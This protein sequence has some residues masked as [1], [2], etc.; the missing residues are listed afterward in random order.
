MKEEQRFSVRFPLDVLKTIKAL[1][2]EDHR[3]INSEIIWI[4]QQ[5]IATHQEKETHVA[6]DKDQTGSL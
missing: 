1:A 3:S 4:L 5:Y 6:D 2:E